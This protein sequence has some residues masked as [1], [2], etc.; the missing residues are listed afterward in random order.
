MNKEKTIN[1]INKLMNEI[2]D[3]LEDETDLIE[4][5]RTLE[6]TLVGIKYAKALVESFKN[7]IIDNIKEEENER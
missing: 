7:N 4:F 3:M 1:E 6:Q 2:V 5:K